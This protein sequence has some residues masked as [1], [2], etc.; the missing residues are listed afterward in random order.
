MEDYTN[1]FNEKFGFEVF[2][3]C[4]NG[5]VKKRCPECNHKSLSCNIL[6]GVYNCFQCSYSGKLETQEKINIVPPKKKF[7]Q[8]LQTEILQFILD[9]SVLKPSH[10]LYLQK[11]GV[12]Y[13]EKWNVKSVPANL[14]LLL[15]DYTDKQL[16][17]SGLYK[18]N[19]NGVTVPTGALSTDNIIIPYY[20]NGRLVAGK[21]RS[22]I[23]TTVSK[24]K[25]MCFNE[26]PV[27]DYVYDC[28]IPNRKT[29]IITE[30]EKKAMVANAYGFSTVAFGGMSFTKKSIKS[31]K[32]V[33][34]K[35]NI[36]RLFIILDKDEDFLGSKSAKIQ[37]CK[38]YEEFKKIG[39]IVFL[40]LNNPEKVGLDDF[41]LSHSALDL[42][43]ILESNWITREKDYIKWKAQIS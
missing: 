29:L 5:Q 15:K 32:E 28:T 6:V 18:D 19:G 9:N 20:Y 42:E 8:K 4:S 17:K 22:V 21:T 25:Y 33:I 43:S 35:H 2:Q 11:S 40:D 38:L 24:Y 14:R 39:C 13:P 16:L 27:L 30:G 23:L 31:L 10:R 41:L 7:S 3:T 26:S 34:K 1:L 12:L 36:D 37:A